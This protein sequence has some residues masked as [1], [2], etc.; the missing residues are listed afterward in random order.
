[1]RLGIFRIE[2]ERDVVLLDRFIQLAFL[3]QCRGVIEMRFCAVRYIGNHPRRPL[4][5][6]NGEMRLPK[7]QRAERHH[8]YTYPFQAVPCPPR[9]HT[10]E[11]YVSGSAGEPERLTGRTLPNFPDKSVVIK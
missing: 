6:G 8:E 9:K 11:R 10:A 1:M 3:L 5:V 7:P 2:L 4:H